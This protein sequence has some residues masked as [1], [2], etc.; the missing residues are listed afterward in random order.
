MYFYCIIMSLNPLIALANYHQFESGGTINQATCVESR[1]LLVCE[2]GKGK[3][4][5]NSIWYEMQQDDFFILPWRHSIKY[6]ADKRIPFLLSGIHIIPDAKENDNLNFYNVAHNQKNTLFDVPW[7]QDIYI[8]NLSEVYSGKLSKHPALYHLTRYILDLFTRQPPDEIQMRSLAKLLIQE[9]EI[10]TKESSKANE[11]KSRELDTMI[12]YIEKNL[13]RKI[14]LDELTHIA[15][16]S[17][18]TVIRLFKNHLALTPIAFINQK[19][20]QK[21]QKLLSSSNQPI[22]LVAAKVGIPDQFYFSKIFKRH[23]GTTPLAYR[24]RFSI[25]HHSN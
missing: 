18:S 7:R 17:L 5:I 14:D 8:A 23:I 3:V 21:A 22:G 15:D 13:D 10:I 19:R 25:L 6:E 24:K 12:V 16:I 4:C 11:S 20:I 1:M 9:W 2:S